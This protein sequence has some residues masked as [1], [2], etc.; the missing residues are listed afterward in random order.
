[1]RRICSLEP[2]LFT[3]SLNLGEFSPLL[4]E[5]SRQ[6]SSS[7]KRPETTPS[8]ALKHFL[9]RRKKGRRGKRGTK[10]GKAEREEEEEEEEEECGARE[11]VGGCDGWGG[12]GVGAG[13]GRGGGG[14]VGGIRST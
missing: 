6:T 2:F 5:L 1:M 4:P 12:T 3:G 9:F 13:V 10:Q 8:W 7:K 11:E 14:E